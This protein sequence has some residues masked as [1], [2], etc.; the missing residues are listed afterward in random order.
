MKKATSAGGIVTKIDNGILKICLVRPSIPTEEYVF[1]KGHL[2]K[3]ETI[4]AAALR[5]VQEE[6]GLPNLAIIKYLGIVKRNSEEKDGTKVIK[7][8]HLYLMST[9]NYEHGEAEEDYK[10]LSIEEA[11]KK[12]HFKKE[13]KFLNKNAKLITHD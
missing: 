8:I 12:M 13:R 7:T 9:D 2:K 10:W 11:L 1:P 6:T 4:E 5:E 3:N